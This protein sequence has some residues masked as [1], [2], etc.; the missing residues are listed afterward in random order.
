MAASVSASAAASTQS[1][2]PM[3][4]HDL[5]HTGRTTLAGP[6]GKDVKW[7]FPTAGAPGSP[8]IGSDGTVYL[9]AGE[10]DAEGMGT[11]TL[12]AINAN[13][14]QK[15]AFA[16]PG[17]PAST[18]P[19][20]GPD[21]TIYVHANGPQNLASIETLTAVSPNGTLKWQCLFNGGSAIFTSPVQSSPAVASD[22]RIWVG[23]IDTNLYS[24]NPADGSVA[25]SVSPSVSSIA[26][27]PAI[28]PDGTVYVVDATTT[29]FAYEPD[30]DPK[31]SFQLTAVG[32]GNNQSPAVAP[33]GTI[34][35]G[36]PGDNRL[37]AV[38][39]N[40]AKKCHFQTGFAI[41][42]TPAIATDGTVYVGSNGLY[43][44]NPANCTQYW[45]FSNALFSGASPIVDNDGTIFWREAW[46][47]YAVNPNGTEMWSLATDPGRSADLFPIG[48][49]GADRTLYLPDGGFV[50]PTRLRAIADLTPPAPP[51]LTDSDPDSPANDNSPKIKGTAEA[52]STVKLFTSADC[53][54]AIAA[55]GTAAAFA[56]TGL[57]V[58]VPDDSSTTF[59]ATATD[60]VG[61][62]SGCSSSSLT[63]VEASTPGS[64]QPPSP[65]P[66][67]GQPPFL[68]VASTPTPTDRTGPKVDVASPSLEMD[69]KG[70]V[71]VKVKCPSG[72][73]A[74]CTGTLTLR[75]ASKV[76]VLA[77]KKIVTLGTARLKVGAGKTVKVKV[78]LSSKNRTLV[79]RL[80]RLKVTVTVLARDQAQN[81]RTITKTLKLRAR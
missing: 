24:L 29:L 10:Y 23:S 61:N 7:S 16:L 40:G 34:W 20:I 15:W 48:A 44:V 55:Q 25:C 37:Y 68:Q 75:T 53:T 26:S 62:A 31:W 52:G 58:S 73:P 80:K 5:Q 33:D 76:R 14:T 74:G 79:R 67:P 57:G 28:A 12:Y 59:R 46:T 2:W 64:G 11:G 39:P 30:C 42:S 50:G 41:S 21:G 4:Q 71:A 19:A 77:K 49:V 66:G 65:Q 63:Y 47:S 54:G 27:S 60:A 6:D 38:N 9:P 51:T 36:S 18:A 78:K 35:V 81:A 22:G 43:A 8:A 70:Y 13:G 69:R 56:S 3:F 72:E 17:P 45:K 32:T 1:P